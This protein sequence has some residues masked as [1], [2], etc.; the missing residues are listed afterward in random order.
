M[1]HDWKRPR[2]R[3]GGEVRMQLLLEARE[4]DEWYAF[5]LPEPEFVFM[6]NSRL[7][8]AELYTHVLDVKNLCASAYQ[9]VVCV[10]KFLATWQCWPLTLAFFFWWVL[11]WLWPLEFLPMVLLWCALLL[12]LLRQEKWNKK[13]FWHSNVAPLNEDGFDLVASFRDTNR[14]EAWIVR[15]LGSLGREASEPTKLRELAGLTFR[16]GRPVM[17]FDELVDLLQKERWVRS[18]SAPRRCQHGHL[19]VYKGCTLTTPWT[20]MNHGGCQHPLTCKFKGSVSRY[21]CESCGIDLCEPCVARRGSLPPA[22]AGIPAHLLPHG[23]LVFLT[24]VEQ[25]ADDLHKGVNAAFDFFLSIPFDREPVSSL[26]AR[27]LYSAFVL[28]WLASTVLLRLVYLISDE[29][30]GFLFRLLCK[31]FGLLVIGCPLAMRTS[32]MQSMATQRRANAEL[33]KYRQRRAAG[34]CATHWAFFK[35]EAVVAEQR[36][37]SETSATAGGLAAIR[38]VP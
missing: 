4:E 13:I 27:W 31:S 24:R 1:P 5:G 28:G 22:W 21:R 34:G 3:N 25:W 36:R 16:N 8:L 32:F 18:T 30:F 12:W 7:N 37:P 14:M 19:I 35:A 33:S 26:K 29:A 11:A 20:C 23:V 38:V 2:R 15:L 6:P 9:K 17:C 10:P